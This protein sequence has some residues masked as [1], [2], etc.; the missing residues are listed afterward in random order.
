[1]SRGQYNS[2]TTRVCPAFRVIKENPEP[3]FNLLHDKL[4]LNIE[5]LDMGEVTIKFADPEK[6]KKERPLNPNPMYLKWLLCNP[7]KTLIGDK[8]EKKKS[9]REKLSDS[10]KMRWKLLEEVKSGKTVL[11]KEGLDKIDAIIE[12]INLG[13]EKYYGK[14]WFILEGSTM[15]DV[16]IETN[17]FYMIVEGKRRESGPKIGTTWYKKRHQMVRHLEGLV[18]YKHAKDNRHE[19]NANK[20][21][22]GIFIVDGSIAKKYKLERYI[23]DDPFLESLPHLKDNKKMYDEIK[24]SFLW[25]KQTHLTWRQIYDCYAKQDGKKIKYLKSTNPDVSYR[26]G[27]YER[28]EPG[29]EEL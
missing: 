26:S 28:E 1:M 11:R 14:E 22:Y 9:R 21:T 10:E 13:R 15:P 12:K 18:C 23:E 20:P 29:F 5:G 8:L 6:E 19:A 16:F 24:Q 2:S 4:G 7:D 17:R 25:G 27:E 3:F